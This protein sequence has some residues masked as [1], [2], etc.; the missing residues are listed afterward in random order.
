MSA[1]YGSDTE[2][3]EDGEAALRTP[4]DCYDAQVRL[5]L[6][7]LDQH[8]S[9]LKE[10]HRAAIDV[11]ARLSHQID[12][13]ANVRIATASVPKSADRFHGDAPPWVA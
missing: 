1:G 12:A 8:L 5:I 6:D 9:E 11:A 2:R 4:A 10:E 7:Q 3:P 13:I